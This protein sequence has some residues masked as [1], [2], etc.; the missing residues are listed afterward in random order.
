VAFAAA[1]LFGV[2]SA[3][4]AGEQTLSGGDGNNHGRVTVNIAQF[5]NKTERAPQDKDGA[6][7]GTASIAAN[8]ETGVAAGASATGND[9]GDSDVADS[10]A[11]ASETGS[12]DAAAGATEESASGAA[13]VFLS[14]GDDVCMGAG[15]VGFQNLDIGLSVSSS[16]QDENCVMLKNARELKNQGHDKAAKAR[17]CMDDDNALAFE[18][19][20]EPCPRALPSTQAALARI[21]E[22]N[23]DYARADAQPVQLAALDDSAIQADGAQVAVLPPAPDEKDTEWLSGGFDGFVTAIKTFFGKVASGAYVDDVSAADSPSV[24]DMPE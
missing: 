7:K 18:L 17:L 3:A 2:T 22:W 24:W 8:T 21:R 19:A 4:A 20:G 10:R 23:P 14:T 16:W 5:V 9:A 1:F 11:S 6:A 12:G 15:G 13:P